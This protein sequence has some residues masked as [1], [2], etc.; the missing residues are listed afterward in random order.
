MEKRG[1]FERCEKEREVRSRHEEKEKRGVDERREK[2]NRREE[3]T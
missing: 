2:E 3:L 1:V